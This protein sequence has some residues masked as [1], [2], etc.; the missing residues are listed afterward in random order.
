[1][2]AKILTKIYQWHIN[3]PK[4]RVFILCLLFPITIPLIL[5]LKW[6][7]K[8]VAFKVLDK[9][10]K[11][12]NDNQIMFVCSAYLKML[13]QRNKWK[14]KLSKKWFSKIMRKHERKLYNYAIED[15]AKISFDY[16]RTLLDIYI[17]YDIIG[18]SVMS[19][20]SDTII[21]ID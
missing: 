1:M 13:A 11:A 14:I 10:I 12:K 18:G 4:L 7:I 21:K 17:Q 8:R 5:Y 2:K 19:E 6:Y 9:G 16:F 15:K 3:H 20:T